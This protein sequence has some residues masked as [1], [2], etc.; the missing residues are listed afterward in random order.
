MEIKREYWNNGNY[1][2][3]DGPAVIKYNED[4]SKK[5]EFYYIDGIEYKDIFQ[6][7]VVS[8]SY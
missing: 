7:S 8:G 1:H 4:G 3:V 2:R 6:Y 5:E